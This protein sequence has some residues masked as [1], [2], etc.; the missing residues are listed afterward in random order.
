MLVSDLPCC[1]HAQ[2]WWGGGGLWGVVWFYSSAFEV[3]SFPC[4]LL[5]FQL[6][7][8]TS[9]G[10][11]FACFLMM[12]YRGTNNSLQTTLVFTIALS[13][14]KASLQHVLSLAGDNVLPSIS[15]QA[16][17]AVLQLAGLATTGVSPETVVLILQTVQAALPTK[18]AFLSAAQST[19]FQL[20]L[21]AQIPFLLCRHVLGAF[22]SPCHHLQVLQQACWLQGQ[23]LADIQ[24]QV[25]QANHLL[26]RPLYLRFRFCICCLLLLA[27]RMFACRRAG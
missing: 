5:P 19:L 20:S 4:A 3:N 23:V 25:G 8:V 9:L 12:G 14:E 27:A 6:C 7:L 11:S 24:C 26:C 16:S 21:S 22:L 1:G 18:Q 17:Q 15:L 10:L 13:E 2:R